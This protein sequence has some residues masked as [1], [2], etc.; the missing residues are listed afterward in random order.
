M[1]TLWIRPLSLKDVD[2]NVDI[3]DQTTEFEGCGGQKSK[4]LAKHKQLTNFG[5]GKVQ[6]VHKI[7][8]NI[9]FYSSNCEL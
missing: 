9:T 8:K 5:T 6:F 7:R 1:W 4:H 2:K 3:M